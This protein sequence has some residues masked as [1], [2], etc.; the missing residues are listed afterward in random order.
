MLSWW[1]RRTEYL[2]RSSRRIPTLSIG[3]ESGTRIPCGV[4][5]AYDPS[6]PSILPSRADRGRTRA[7][8][9]GSPVLA[10]PART[11]ATPPSGSHMQRV[12][13]APRGASFC[14]TCLRVVPAPSIASERLLGALDRAAAATCKNRPGQRR[15]QQADFAVPG[16]PTVTAVKGALS[17]A[18]ALQCRVGPEDAGC[19]RGAQ[20]RLL[21]AL[22]GISGDRPPLVKPLSVCYPLDH[23]TPPRPA[24]ALAMPA[25]ASHNEGSVHE[26]ECPRRGRSCPSML[27][28]KSQR[29]YTVQRPAHDIGHPARLQPI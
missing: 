17:A 8:R 22:R 20:K 13:S 23:H 5:C 21:R 10:K 14:Y 11:A 28:L 24:S 7:A 18:V 27:L 19:V 12:D 1:C 9:G 29:C 16:L 3:R 4:G 15:S 26:A 2:A 6:G 25:G